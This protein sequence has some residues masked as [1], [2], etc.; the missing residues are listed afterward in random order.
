MPGNVAGHFFGS[1][2]PHEKT[3][4]PTGEQPEAASFTPLHS[5]DA[6][7]RG[8]YKTTRLERQQNIEDLLTVPILLHLGDL[9][10]PT[11]RDARL[12]DLG[13]VES[14]VAFDGLWPHDA[15]YNPLTNVEVDADFLPTR[16]HQISGG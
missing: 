2:T 5:R 6:K 11:I 1:F 12:C 15:G 13:G 10:T 3:R 8:S 4:P 9:A 14:I 7:R 16:D